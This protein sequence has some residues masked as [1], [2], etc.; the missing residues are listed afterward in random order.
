MALLGPGQKVRGGQNRAL[1]KDKGA[2]GPWDWR[3]NI[4]N[5]G[6]RQRVILRR[7]GTRRKNVLTFVPLQEAF[8]RP[9]RGPQPG[10][11]AGGAGSGEACVWK[12][13]P[14]LLQVSPF[15]PNEENGRAGGGVWGGFYLALMV[16]FQLRGSWSLTGLMRENHRGEN[17]QETAGKRQYYSPKNNNK[18]LKTRPKLRMNPKAPGAK[19]K[20]NISS[21]N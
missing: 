12:D 8:V 2:Q 18:P 5:S 10:G 16:L 7:E 3:P 20:E 17:S 1:S 4:P 9:L 11:R 6:S 15:I 14:L 21:T 13:R 19:T